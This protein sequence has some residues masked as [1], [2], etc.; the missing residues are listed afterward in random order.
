MELINI[1][2]R[3]LDEDIVIEVTEK[4]LCSYKGNSAR[5]KA[6]NYII[7][8]AFD[9]LKVSSVFKNDGEELVCQ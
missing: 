8:N 4:T 7:D 1:E 6:L 2:V 9:D 3:I 5:E